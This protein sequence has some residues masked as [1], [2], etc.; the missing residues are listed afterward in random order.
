MSAET[1]RAEEVLAFFRST[2]Q[3]R[4]AR[5][6]TSFTDKDARRAWVEGGM[7]EKMPVVDDACL[8]AILHNASIKTG[9]IPPELHKGDGENDEKRWRIFTFKDLEWS[10]ANWK[11]KLRICRVV[12]DAA[13]DGL[14]LPP[15]ED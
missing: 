13:L 3:D 1:E 2:F 12:R 11:P 7:A 9:S 10:L 5:R 14:G 4:V 8:N 6:Y 15:A